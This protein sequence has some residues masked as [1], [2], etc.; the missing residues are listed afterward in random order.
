MEV[1][2]VALQFLF[3]IVVPG[4]EGSHLR[5]FLDES[6]VQVKESPFQGATNKEISLQILENFESKHRFVGGEP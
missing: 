3:D 1:Q 5:V 4:D 2:H 6:I